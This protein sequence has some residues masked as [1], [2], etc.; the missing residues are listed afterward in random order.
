MTDAGG[1]DDVTLA[2]N[3]IRLDTMRCDARFDKMEALGI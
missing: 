1:A 3:T 2:V